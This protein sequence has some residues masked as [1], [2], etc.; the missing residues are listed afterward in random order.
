MKTKTKTKTK[1]NKT[2]QKQ[3]QKNKH[4]KDTNHQTT[5][6]GFLFGV[7]LLATHLSHVAEKRSLELESNDRVEIRYYKFHF[8]V[9]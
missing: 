8:L 4:K 2:K 9:F 7:D 1:Q 6:G 3:K 5:F